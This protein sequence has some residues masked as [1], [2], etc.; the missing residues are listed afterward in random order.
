MFVE[1]KK[2]DKKNLYAHYIE[3]EKKRNLEVGY[4][5]DSKIIL[6]SN[7]EINIKDA[8]IKVINYYHRKDIDVKRNDYYSPLIIYVYWILRNWKKYND[9]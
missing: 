5:I 1:D 3:E 4:N 6:F 8:L 2:L 7:L 9:K